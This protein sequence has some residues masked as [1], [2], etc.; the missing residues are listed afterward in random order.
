MISPIL[1]AVTAIAALALAT[2][3]PPPPALK[4]DSLGEFVMNA[5][6][7]P[8]T[9]HQ[10][11]AQPVTLASVMKNPEKLLGQCV[12]IAGYWQARALF[13]TARH[14]RS[15]RSVLS[16]KVAQHRVGLYADWNNIG[17]PPKNP[18]RTRFVGILGN[19]ETQW[20]NAVMVMGYC[21]YTD[22]PILLVSQR[23]AE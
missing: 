1:A 18:T 21:H 2:D 5:W 22:G 10:E 9:C 15:H 23:I 13:A 8:E 11:V 16:K 20:A 17:D 19:C 7:N 12:I 6:T 4:D 3:T 14:A